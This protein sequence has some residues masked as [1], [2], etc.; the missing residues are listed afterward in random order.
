M[1][2]VRSRRDANQRASR[3]LSGRPPRQPWPGAPT[4]AS[5]RRGSSTS[6]FLL[7]HPGGNRRR[8]APAGLQWWRPAQTDL[9]NHRVHRRS[10]QT[11]DQKEGEAVPKSA[12]GPVLLLVAYVSG[13]APAPN[14]GGQAGAERNQTGILR[15]IIPGHYVYSYG[16][17]NSGIIVT[18]EGLVVLDALNSEAVSRAQREAM[19]T[20]IR[21][22][23]RVLV[24][25]TFHNPYSKG[26]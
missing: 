15:Q 4:F 24:S 9:A 12:L 5:S 1:G 22:P 3:L 18:S 17:F 7:S 25:S 13:Q 6:R 10:F 11:R 8:S 20:A 26:N 23:V 2:R 16:T 14:P 21:E 19:A